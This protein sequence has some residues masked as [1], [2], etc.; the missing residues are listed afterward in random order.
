MLALKVLLLTMVPL[1]M[2]GR[3]MTL[4]AK[5]DVVQDAAI[6]YS[7][8]PGTL[9]VV[10][11][12]D[13][14][15]IKMECKPSSYCGRAGAPVTV[16]GSECT[17]EGNFITS[18][19][20]SSTSPFSTQCVQYKRPD[21]EDYQENCGVYNIAPKGS[22]PQ[23]AGPAPQQP[24]DPNDKPVPVPVP[25]GGNNGGS[26]PP[27]PSNG[28]GRPPVPIAVDSKIAVQK[29]ISQG[30]TDFP[31]VKGITPTATGWTVHYCRPRCQRTTTTKQPTTTPPKTP[32]KSPADCLASCNGGGSHGSGANKR[33][34][35]TT[36]S[37]TCN[38]G[39]CQCGPKEPG[40]GGSGGG[41][42]HCFSADSTVTTPTGPMRMDGLKIGSQVLVYN[43]ATGQQSYESVDS[44]LHR[45]SDL[46]TKFIDIQTDAGT[47]MSLTPGHLVPIVDCHAPGTPDLITAN[48][49]QLGQ[50]V[51]VN[52]EGGVHPSPVVS[53]SESTK[54]GIYAPLTRSG[55]LM[56]D[57]MVGSCYS[58][59]SESFQ[60]QNT[61]YRFFMALQSMLLMDGGSGMVEVPTVLHLF[62]T[63]SH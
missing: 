3:H 59:S 39:V 25:V 40:H 62:D 22:Q 48:E 47:S 18:I 51:L 60:V 41:P 10:R 61:F 24:N 7:C 44:F 50:C 21:N 30:N 26:G 6:N 33:K 15:N 16:Q 23:P 28:Q 20:K 57:D 31:A 35:D 52:R 17:G 11:S 49:V 14:D 53:L 46:A 56:V 8:P 4:R 1:A 38:D 9:L 63:I 55:T 32:C 45:R 19:K 37:A 27:R 42:F 36:G 29:N 54:T 13:V 43:E 34:R 2:A 12:H 5:R 58:H